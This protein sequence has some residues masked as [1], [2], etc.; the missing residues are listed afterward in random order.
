[1]Y[2]LDTEEEE[3]KL[4]ETSPESIKLASTAFDKTHANR[5]FVRKLAYSEMVSVCDHPRLF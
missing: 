4:L 1:M 5:T 2:T 3:L